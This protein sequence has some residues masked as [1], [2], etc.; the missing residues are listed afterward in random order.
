M[1]PEQLDAIPVG[2]KVR[3]ADALVVLTK[4][5]LDF[6]ETQNGTTMIAS[7]VSEFANTLFPVDPE[8]NI[9]GWTTNKPT[10]PG[11][12]LQRE[13]YADIA[14]SNPE[15]PT[16]GLWGD[17]VHQEIAM[18]PDGP[19]RKGPQGKFHPVRQ[20]TTFNTIY[21][22]GPLPKMPDPREEAVNA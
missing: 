13:F 7:Y 12:Y 19:K 22:L 5:E 9:E 21:W 1:T 4:V 17:V 3:T 18:F 14:R 15:E 11:D 20:S 6:W 2:G 8:P 10:E 16:D